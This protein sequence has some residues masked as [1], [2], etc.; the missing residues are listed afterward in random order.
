MKC[1]RKDRQHKDLRNHRNHKKAKN[2]GR[3]NRPA[4]RPRATEP[5]R[6]RHH[7]G[8]HHQAEPWKPK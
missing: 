6:E 2:P 8:A 3:R 4:A 7:D 5:F 1:W